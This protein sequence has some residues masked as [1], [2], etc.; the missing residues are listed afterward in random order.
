MK[1]DRRLD[2]MTRRTELTAL[3]NFIIVVKLAFNKDVVTG[4]ALVDMYAK[5]CVQNDEFV[6]G[7]EL[8]KEMLKNGI[9]ISQ[10][11]YA[12]VYRSCTGLSAFRLGAQLHDH[13]LKTCFESDIIV[14]MPL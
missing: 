7:L 3:G 10:S 14:G 8:F 12:R 2:E 5:C 6:K 9:E 4:S 1:T 11:I 13:A